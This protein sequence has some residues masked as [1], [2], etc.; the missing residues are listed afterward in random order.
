[1]MLNMGDWQRWKMH[2]TLN[3]DKAGSNPASPT[4]VRGI[5]R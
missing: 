5:G 3:R 4:R 1:L 2:S